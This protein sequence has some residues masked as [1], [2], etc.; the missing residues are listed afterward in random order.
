MTDAL[1]LEDAL[2]MLD[3]LAAMFLRVARVIDQITFVNE[4]GIAALYLNIFVVH[5]SMLA[6]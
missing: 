5:T 2:D 6:Q 3:L 4:F 1:K